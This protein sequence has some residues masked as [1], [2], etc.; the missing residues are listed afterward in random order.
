MTLNRGE[1]LV[2][3]RLF[4][5]LTLAAALSACAHAISIAPLQTPA[6]VE[7]TANSKK[8]AYVMTDADRDT[9][10]VTSGGGGDKIKYLPYRDLEKAIRD[11][12]RSV[13]SDVVAIKSPKDAEALAANG[14]SLV[15][16]PKISTTSDSPS[17]FTWPPTS[18][19]IDLSC[20][21]TDP[22]GAVVTRLKVLGVGAAEFSEFK[23]DFG[24]A[25]RRAASDLS[26][27]LRDAVL[28]DP[29]LQ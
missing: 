24:L 10:V 17:I 20:D 12:L 16:T 22:A 19:N 26:R 21:V 9:P 7:P 25:G 8:V 18:F 23:G 1:D 13:F 28:A 4:V 2:S 11:A 14:T 15:F 27:K 29:K 6:R 5:A 3:I